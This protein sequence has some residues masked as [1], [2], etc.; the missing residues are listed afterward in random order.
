MLLANWPAPPVEFVLVELSPPMPPDGMAP[1]GAA[2]VGAAPAATAVVPAAEDA[3]DSAEATD[4]ADEAAAEAAVAAATV[5]EVVECVDE[6]TAAAVVLDLID[7]ATAEATTELDL[8]LA[9]AA[10]AEAPA[11]LAFE[12]VLRVLLECLVS[13]EACLSVDDLQLVD[14]LS[15]PWLSLLLLLLLLPLPLLLLLSWLFPRLYASSR[16]AWRLLSIE[17]K[18]SLWNDNRL[19]RNQLL[20]ATSSRKR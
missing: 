16:F 4:A 9:D 12:D 14:F 18:I 6:T 10:T 8:L 3:A 7:V 5:V 13:V 11:E 1:V 2:P 20:S 19:H 15:L 17:V